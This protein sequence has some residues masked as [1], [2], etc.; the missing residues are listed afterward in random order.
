MN[1]SARDKVAIAQGREVDRL[2]DEFEAALKRGE[3]P[4][5]AT[6][7]HGV[8][9]SMQSQ[10][11]A[12]LLK[13]ELDYRKRRGEAVSLAEYASAWCGYE[14]EVAAVFQASDTDE[15]GDELEPS[16]RSGDQVG[17]FQLVE[18]VGTGSFGTVYRAYDAKLDRS[19]AIKIPASGTLTGKA[20]QR[21]LR[22]AQAAAR[23][24]H[25]HIVQVH[26]VHVD[27]LECYIVSDFIDGTTL[28]E[29]S[30][31]RRMTHAEAASLVAKLA[32]AMHYANTMGIVHRDLKPDNVMVDAAGQPLIMDFGLAKKEEDDASR[33]HDGTLL[34]TPA[35]M[36]PEQAAG[37]GHE[38]DDKS[39]QWSLGVILYEL[40]TARRPYDGSKAEILDG[41]RSEDEPPGPRH[42]D[43]SIPPDLDTICQKCLTKRPSL[44]YASCQHLASD[45][46]SWLRGEPIL[47][48]PVSAVERSWRWCQR[49]QIATTSLLMTFLVLVG[50]IVIVTALWRDAAKAR[51]SADENFA[52]ARQVIDTI[53]TQL[54]EDPKFRD[55]AEFRDVQLGLLESSVKFFED[56]VSLE[57]DD[58]TLQAERGR[59]YWLLGVA[60]SLKHERAEALAAF[61]HTES[62]YSEL[63]R[64]F[65]DNLDYRSSW[66]WSLGWQAKML[67]EL[68]RRDEASAA[69]DNGI[70]IL[71]EVTEREPDH[72]L[73][74][75][76]L[77]ACYLQRGV[78]KEE[79]GDGTSAAADYLLA[80]TILTNEL[81]SEDEFLVG[82][83]Q[84][85][86]QLALHK[87]V[88]QLVQNH[89]WP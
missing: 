10:L 74:V 65:P 64:R 70:V 59:A 83:R 33:T 89:E 52:W 21:F 16:D 53:T 78:L 82:D 29:V 40:L 60:R 38:A 11:F 3:C 56:F 12:E 19:V 63:T 51:D 26:E 73:A 27:D 14:A 50:A 71:E 37:R 42:G 15:T 54:V 4:S 32:E 87:H 79:L 55:R 25:P 47:A 9:E 36:S 35:Y 49:N 34:G 81:K 57:G 85:Y 80:V 72:A 68:G 17:P 30:R 43:K 58:P 39:D 76:K 41:L 24:R 8:D 13:L 20:R 61:E 66:G 5:I 6:A 67:H 44:R 28:G 86:L 77:G 18:K 2:C 45:L 7:L 75:V 22:E 69:C 62:I 1:S 48:R 46:A 88:A 84:Y 23:L 31:E